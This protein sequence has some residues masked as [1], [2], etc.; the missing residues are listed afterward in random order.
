[1]ILY[2]LSRGFLAIA[3]NDTVLDGK[4]GKEM[5]IRMMNLTC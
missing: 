3:R 5:A 1:M 4:G 2:L